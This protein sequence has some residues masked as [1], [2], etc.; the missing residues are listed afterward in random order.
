VERDGRF[1]ERPSDASTVDLEAASGSAETVG[2]QGA[3]PQQED[4]HR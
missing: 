3:A 1:N 2:P 4:P